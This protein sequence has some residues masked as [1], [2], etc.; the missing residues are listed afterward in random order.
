MDRRPRTRWW[1]LPLAAGA[2][3]TGML[4]T[5][6]L[7][8]QACL[9]NSAGSPGWFALSYGRAA[10]DASVRGVDAGWQISRA[11]TVFGDGN[12]T[13]YPDPDPARDRLA[14]GIAYALARSERFGVCLTPGIEGERISDVHVLR[15]PIGISLG[16]TTTPRAGR[17][18]LGVQVEPFWVYSRETIAEF[19]STS[20]FVSVR[21]AVVFSIQ[22]LFIGIVH[23]QTFDGDA[24]W[25]TIGRIGF[26]FQ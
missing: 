3:A 10:K 16:W 17:P 11:F 24:Q 4:M 1:A 26:A 6:P 22:Q 20:H 14:I 13:A 9:G 23:E 8:A 5:A 25:H 15:V 7:A 2:L 21:A 18:R 19:S 12:V